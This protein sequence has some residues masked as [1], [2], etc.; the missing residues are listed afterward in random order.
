M[1]SVKV[2]REVLL[3]RIRGNRDAHRAIFEDALIGYRRLA[4]Q[5]L[6][7]SLEEAR[8]GRKIRRSLTLVEPE[9]HTGEYDRVIDMLENSVDDEITLDAGSY[10][11]YMRDEWAWKRQFLASNS[12]YTAMVDD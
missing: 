10:A 1:H 5:E 12:G 11:Q 3:E 9:D 8:S 4:V 2:K 7:H 6:E